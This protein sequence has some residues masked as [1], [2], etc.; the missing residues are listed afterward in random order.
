[1]DI[2]Q[3]KQYKILLI[4]DSCIDKFHYGLC[5][6]LSPEAPIPILVHVKT[7]ETRGMVKN[8]KNNL[9]S[10]GKKVEIKCLTN[11]EKILKERFVEINS[12]QHILRF[13]SGE[14]QDIEALDLDNYEINNISKYDLVIVSDYNKGFVTAAVARKI[15]EECI[16]YNIPVFVDTKKQDISCFKG[17]I[18]KINQKEFDNLKCKFL[19]QQLIITKGHAGTHW[20][21][22]DFPTTAAQVVDVSGAGDTFLAFLSYK[23]ISSNRDM[24]AAIKFA[25]RAAS[26]SVCKSGTYSL[27]EEDIEKLCL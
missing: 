14:D 8:V 1:M 6:R 20:N 3:Q 18:V 10:F 23:Y 15:C 16:L 2:L 7:I 12:G 17:S 26:Y 27:K 5:E 13:D 4:G 19:S 11:K 25:N 21:G 24:A 22:I 9:L